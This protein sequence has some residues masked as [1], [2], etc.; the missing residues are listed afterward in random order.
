MKILFITDKYWPRPLANAICMQ[1]IADSFTDAGHSVDILA[2]E[3]E[4]VETPEEHNGSRVFTV[5]PSRQLRLL[6]NARNFPD[7]SDA[8]ASMNKGLRLSRIKHALLLPWFPLSSLSA[9]RRME[10]KIEELYEDNQYD[11]VVSVFSPFDAAV[12]GFRFKR[13]HPECFWCLYTLDTFVNLR[14]SKIP[15]RWRDAHYWIPRFLS[16][17]DMFVCMK[18]RAAWYEERG[19][20]ELGNGVTPSDIPL[21]TERSSL[22]HSEAALESANWVYAG[23]LY[24]THYDTADLL[25]I[26]E[27]M[28]WDNGL[29]VHFYS[30]GKEAESLKEHPL[31]RAG[32]IVVHGYVDH[33]ELMRIYDSAAV[34]LSIKTSDQ[35]SA[36]IFEYM[37]YGKPILHIS[38]CENDPNIHYVEKY[39]KGLA[40]RA[41]EDTSDECARIIEEWAYEIANH[42]QEC[43]DMSEFVMN[44]PSYTRDLLIDAYKARRVI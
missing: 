14:Q 6:N 24:K 20:A 11:M 1:N 13:K 8:K 36:K 40:I 34:L 26:L 22:T 25:A 17:A 4:G 5:K 16:T 10:N 35:I 42:S 12:S 44:A 37:A 27:K 31:Y 28:N 29:T 30:S 38:S 3:E 15:E 32:K 43:V 41:Y 2:Y 21:L 33:D 39:G 18:S 7:A 19:Y 9:P 23:S